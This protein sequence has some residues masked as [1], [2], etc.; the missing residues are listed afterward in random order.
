MRAVSF[1]LGFVLL[2]TIGVVGVSAKAQP[3][4]TTAAP[5]EVVA[6][7][8]AETPLGSFLDFL[9]ANTAPPR[10][11]ETRNAGGG[12]TGAGG[13]SASGDSGDSGGHQ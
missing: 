3:S 11:M 9:K 7:P 12:G 5:S 6:Q 2:F 4:T 8:A 13:G 1:C 10:T